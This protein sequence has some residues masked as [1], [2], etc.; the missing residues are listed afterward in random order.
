MV[1]SVRDTLC[2]HN[3][4]SGETEHVC[5]WCQ[6]IIDFQP[7]K[8]WHIR[9]P[10]EQHERAI[11]LIG[12]PGSTSARKWNTLADNTHHL[13]H[14]QWARLPEASDPIAQPPHSWEA[15]QDLADAVLRGDGLSLLQEAM[16]REGIVFHDDSTLRYLDSKWNLNGTPLPGLSLFVAFSLIGDAEKR[17]GWNIP[18]LLLCATSV[19]PEHRQEM[20]M[21]QRHLPGPRDLRSPYRPLASMLTWLSTRLKVDRT[22]DMRPE[23]CVPMMAWSHDIQTRMFQR[24]P[25]NMEG[26]FRNALSNHPPGLFHAYDTPWMRAWQSFESAVYHSET[27]KWALDLSAKALRFRSRTKSGLLRLIRVPSEP[28]LWALLSSLALSPLN[29]EAGSLLLGLQH[30]WSVPYVVKPQPSKPLV[31]S[32]EFCHEIMN[33]LDQKV[34]LQNAQVLVIGRLGHVYEIAV[35]HGQHGAPY[36]IQHVI[37]VAPSLKRPVCIHSGRFANTLPLGDTMGGVVLSMVNDVVASKDVESLQSLLFSH[38]PFGFPRQ[39]IPLPWLNAL[40]VETLFQHLGPQYWPD[41]L[42]WYQRE[43]QPDRDRRPGQGL[44]ELLL[45][46]QFHRRNRSRT[47]DRWVARFHTVFDQ[48]GRFPHDELVAEWRTTVSPYHGGNEPQQMEGEFF[49]RFAEGHFNR[50]YHHLMPHRRRDDIHEEGDI[51][52]GERRW[53]EVFARVWEVLVHQP[54]GASFRLPDEDGLPITFENTA[55]QV[56]VRSDI[57]RQFLIRIGRVLGYVKHD[58]SEYHSM[59][60]RRDHPRPNARLQLTDLLSETQKRQRVRGAPPRWWNYVDVIT[61]PR[62]IPHFRWQLQIDHQDARRPVPV[63]PPGDREFIPDGLFG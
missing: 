23:D 45:R 37:D 5:E 16:L 46:N 60:I 21:M 12:D 22:L 53:C 27:Q 14:V 24:Q 19:N 34:F 56:T 62:D 29:S 36:T 33:G 20:P 42:R 26:M 43:D 17:K 48:E 18:A 39:S 6:S 28:S 3:S 54:M 30:N 49:G 44:H 58:D 7:R 9:L 61:P 31:R 11:S 38:A 35:E 32:M 55:L 1:T 50:H 63:D 8:G 40:D 47:S 15:F 25:R 52:D 57:E 4:A 13:N 41:R 59:F 2:K 10:A 51:R